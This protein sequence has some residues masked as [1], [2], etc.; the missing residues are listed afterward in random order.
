MDKD[1][2]AGSAKVIKGTVKDAVGKAVGDAAGIGRQ[3][4]KDQ[5]QG[6]ERPRRPQRHAQ[7]EIG[8]VVAYL[9]PCDF[10]AYPWSNPHGYGNGLET[11]HSKMS[12]MRS[13]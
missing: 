3:G 9:A 6:S 13:E 10:E 2:V 4:R 11:P 12:S 1:R 7:R 5:G 8:V